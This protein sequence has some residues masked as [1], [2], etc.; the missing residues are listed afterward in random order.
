MHVLW[1]VEFASCFDL[2]KVAGFGQ[3]IILCD[4]RIGTDRH[5]CVFFSSAGLVEDAAAAADFLYRFV[6]RHIC[7]FVGLN[8]RSQFDAWF[9]ACAR[10]SHR[11]NSCCDD[12]AAGLKQQS[13]AIDPRRGE[14]SS[15]GADALN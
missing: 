4:C 13:A 12:C 9:S 14:F 3:A 1:Q 5:K 11:F 10:K 2:Q 7:R 8:Q 15:C 6:N